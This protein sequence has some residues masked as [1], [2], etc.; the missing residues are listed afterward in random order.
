VWSWMRVAAASMNFEVPF[1]SSSDEL[2]MAV[3]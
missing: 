2:A 1:D 3:L